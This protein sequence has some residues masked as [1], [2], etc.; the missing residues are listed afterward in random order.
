MLEPA[1]S[2]RQGE[3][4]VST[5]SDSDD[6]GTPEDRPEMP[7]DPQAHPTEAVEALEGKEPTVPEGD[8]AVPAEDVSANPDTD[9]MEELPGP[10][11]D[12]PN[13]PAG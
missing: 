2:S 9:E 12:E 1:A 11:Q 13:E 10:S 8:D 5:T 7:A 4:N 3:T 6:S